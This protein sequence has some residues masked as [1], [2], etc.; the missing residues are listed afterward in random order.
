MKN[1]LEFLGLEFNQL[2]VLMLLIVGSIVAIRVRFDLNKYLENRNKKLLQKLRNACTHIEI[3]QQEDE[4]II[5]RFLFISPPGTL[6]YQC[7]RC[8]AAKY[9]NDGEAEEM[10]SYYANNIDE[11]NKR[12]KRF[13][14]LL[15]KSGY[16]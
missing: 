5:I 11:Y 6:Q 13:S 4:Q 3:I 10:Q 12:M 9:L 1:I 14:K 7:Q 15:K 2:V 8:G 16:V